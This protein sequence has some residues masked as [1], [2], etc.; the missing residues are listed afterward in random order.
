MDIEAVKAFMKE[1]GWG[2]LATSDGQ[3]V[4]VRPMSGWEWFDNELWCASGKAS[5]KITQLSKVPHA[6]YCFGDKEG[7]HIRIA[8]PCTISTDNDD[9]LKLHKAV[10]ALEQYIPDPTADDYVVIRMK[11]DSIRMAGATD[12]SYTEIALK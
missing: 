8:G 12:L 4:G 11:P 10:P 9:K 6:E 1:I 2:S 5:D 3:K 7:K